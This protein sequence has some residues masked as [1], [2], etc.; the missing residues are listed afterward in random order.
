MALIASKGNSNNNSN[1]VEQ[2]LIEAGVYPARIVQILDMGLQ[3][4][5]PYQGK[6]KS[7]ANEISITYELVDSFMLDEKGEE[8]EDKPRWVS[9]IL[10]LYSIDQEKAKSTQRYYAAD[11]DNNYGGDFSKLLDIP[12]NV[13]IVHNKVGD[14]TY[15]N[16]AGIAAMRP[17]DAIKCPAL[18]NPPKILDLD[19]PDVVIFNSLPQWIQDKIKKNLN[20][21]GSK[22][23]AALEGKPVAQEKKAPP[24]EEPVEE[25]DNNDQPWD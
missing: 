14:K 17:K 21:N 12:V 15:V 5:R 19:A 3:A 13:T 20:F 18:V 4:Q 6:E 23:Q 8:L 16:I 11:P 7:P 2:P 24:K 1:R 25:E 10:P 9:E 22:L